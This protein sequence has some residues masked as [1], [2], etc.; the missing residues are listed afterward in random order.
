M[1]PQELRRKAAELREKIRELVAK[2]E[3]EN[4]EVTQDEATTIEDFKA[5]AASY[6][7][8]AKMIE[9]VE[10]AITQ[11]QQSQGRVSTALS[12][13]GVE[14]GSIEPGR[15]EEEK[16]FS[17]GDFLQCVAIA[18][19]PKA[20]YRHRESAQDLLSNLYRSNYNA[21]DDPTRGK[22][23]RA[24]SQSSGAAGGYTVPD[25][26]YDRLMQIAA[27]Q[28]LVRPRATIIPMA[29]DEMDL[30]T[31]DVTTPRSA[32]VP[33]Y[34]GGV[35]AAWS[36]E[37]A[38]IDST[39]A[40]FKQSRLT[41]HELTGYTEVSKTLL[42]N[43]AVSVEALLYQLYG[44]AVAWY[45]DYAFLRG[46]GIGKPLGILNSP[47]LV[48]TA[49]RGSASAISFANATA[50]WTRVLDTSRDRAVWVCS[51]AAEATMLAMAGVANAVFHPTGV[52][53]AGGATQNAGPSGVLLY[54]RPVLVT[55]KMPA[56]NVLGDFLCA[57]FGMY[58]IGDRQ[59]MEVAA[60]EHYKFRN[61]QIAFRF[62]HKVGGR[63]WLNSAITLE[64]GTT[65]VSPFVALQVQ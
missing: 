42:A 21:W 13:S 63:P 64:D 44:G 58:V 57:D 40:N 54:M 47:A 26:F 17:F 16:R 25:S 29:V 33:P 51:Q 30:P 65:T 37:A 34:F 11:G 43:S 1:N 38:T 24:M 50:V 53:V 8:R 56:L 45:E 62:V 2:A 28:S 52:Y 18:G 35:V 4:R 20:S 39:D 12:G 3:A 6:E 27:P 59:Q 19:D 23:V 60:S 31:L 49:A 55:A 22:E 48:A 36:G 14:T 41:A 7:R 10:A 61:N 15:T 9:E 5:M 32:G 46:D